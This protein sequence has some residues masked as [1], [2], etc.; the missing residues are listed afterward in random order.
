MSSLE[1]P[2]IF[3]SYCWADSN[4]ESKVLK[5]ANRL[6]EDGI[7]V[8]LD[9][10]N[11]KLGN[12]LNNFMEQC[13]NDPTINYVLLLLTP[14]YK[15]KADDR[16][17]GAGIETQIISAEVYKDVDNE[18]FIP[19]LFQKNGHKTEECIPT[20]LKGRL[21]LDLS[22]ECDYEKQY[23][24]LL[25]TLYGVDKYVPSPIGSKPAWVDGGN[26]NSKKQHE[27]IIKYMQLKNEDGEK[28]A[29]FDSFQILL[30]K[31]Y[32]L[33]NE[34]KND[35][36]V[37]TDFEKYYPLFR[38]I[39][40]PYLAL[41]QKIKFNTLMPEKIYDFFTACFK[42]IFEARTNNLFNVLAEIFMHELFI[43]TIA[44]L[45][46]YN[47][48]VCIQYLTYRPYF[49]NSYY[50]NELVNFSDLFYSFNYYGVYEIDKF[51]GRKL[52]ADKGEGNYYSGIAEYRMRNIPIN[53]LNKENFIDADCLLTN[54]SISFKKDMWFAIT[55]IYLTNRNNNLISKL[56]IMLKSKAL[57]KSVYYIFNCNN[58][59]DIK[60]SVNNLYKYKVVDRKL[61][62]YNGCFY[63]IP[64]LSDYI[65]SSD[66][67][68][69]D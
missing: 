16:K 40:E 17:G 33:S 18:K 46:K 12:D 2:K 29:I 56:A 43:E 11:L 62:S 25:Q 32:G 58:L 14:E 47:N 7:E 9:K 41:I 36:I 59:N 22:E 10:F 37:F 24:S 48:Y 53:F 35:Q 3:I 61:V 55:Y 49:K 30:E 54:I 8:I 23:V 15:I 42:Y 45:I 63:S 31:F 39:R 50:D 69:C 60:S 5:F 51:L 38:N 28:S 19:I 66:I 67:E 21:W 57:S 4:F 34:I 20:Y 27:L 6:R 64:L 44:I 68:T 1:H 26:D 65:N 13:V 52:Y